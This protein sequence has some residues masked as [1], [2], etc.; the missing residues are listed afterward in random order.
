[1][2]DEQSDPYDFTEDENSEQF[3]LFYTLVFGLRTNMFLICGFSSCSLAQPS[4]K[5]SQKKTVDIGQNRYRL[6]IP[7]QYIPSEWYDISYNIIPCLHSRFQY[8]MCFK[9]W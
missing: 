5:S 6:Q 1:M 9:V 2:A 7:Y 3:W 8:F 4:Q